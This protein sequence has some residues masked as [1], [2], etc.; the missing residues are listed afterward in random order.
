MSKRVL[1]A[2]FKHETNTF[3][4]LPTDLAA[5]QAREYYRDAE[6]VKKMRGT[7]TEVGAALDAGQRHGW[8]MCHPICANAMPSGRGTKDMHD[9]VVDILVT[10]LKK[11]GPFDG[12]YL[13]LHGAMA[14]EHDDDGEGRL[15]QALRDEVGPDMPI[16][17]TLD[18]HANVTDRMADLTNILIS[19]RTYPH[20]DQYEVAT[21]AC[22][23]LQRAMTWEIHPKV[24]VRRREMLDG[25]DHGR[26]TQPGPMTE[27]L[28]TLD[29]LLATTPGTYSG[30]VNAGFPRADTYDTGPS[31]IVVGE[32]NDP[33]HVAIADKVM[34]QIW[35]DRHRLTVR[36]YSVAEAMA[37]VKEAL[38]KGVQAPIVM[39]DFAD[40]PGGGGYGD[41]T[42]LLAGMIEAGLTDAAFGV[43]CDPEAAMA[44]RNAGLGTSL[45]L[46][47]GGKVDPAVQG[48]PL[49]VFGTVT[50]ITDGT[51]AMEGPMT[52][53]AHIDMGPTAVFSV[54]GVDVVI[55]SRRYQNYD[56]MFFKSAGID[57]KKKKVLGVKSAH[58][59]RAAYGPIASRIIVVDG[60][61]GLTSN[62]FKELPY[63]NVRRPVYPLDLE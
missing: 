6:V 10:A 36:M 42:R 23:L 7:R 52:K 21:Q 37:Q 63:K 19:Y 47:I 54:G 34:E 15:L 60:G 1:I 14:C 31:C 18:L 5:Y 17:A 51:F 9:H 53:G 24:H 30:S 26:T 13:C 58:H 40:N 55:S 49:S 16:A 32:G 41:A 25:A 20:V 59:F 38:A 56:Q 29:K 8:T 33:A 4:V 44:C 3:S 50:A 12:I 45:K 62:N 22:D 27:A 61:G 11:D 43:L 48:G 46:D 35:Q 2:A 39:N 28:D 57:P